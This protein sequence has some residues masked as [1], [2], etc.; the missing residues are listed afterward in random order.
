MYLPW[1]AA[2]FLEQ[3]QDSGSLVVF[4]IA[5][6]D[7]CSCTQ[8]SSPLS[9]NASEALSSDVSCYPAMAVSIHDVTDCTR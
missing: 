6:R 3:N 4:A 8:E 5:L 1:Y 9:P 2:A 7:R